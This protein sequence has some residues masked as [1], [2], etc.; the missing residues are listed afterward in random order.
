MNTSKELQFFDIAAN[1]TDHQFEGVY[2]GKKYH[3]S[4]VLDVIERAASMGCNHLLIASGCLEDVK[5][6]L[7]LCSL[8]KNFYTT[9]GIH[10]CRAAEPEKDEKYWEKL[11]QAI[12]EGIKEKKLLM[13]GEC[14]LD[15][16]RL[17]WSTKE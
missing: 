1:L 12:E 5:Q 16:D 9:G 14:G 6:A 13:I 11:V 8:S 10:P 17:E 2:H 3:D 7:K 15:Y 4:D